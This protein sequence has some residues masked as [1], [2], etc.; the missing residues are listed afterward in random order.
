MSLGRTKTMYT[1]N[2]GIAPY[3]TDTLKGEIA[4]SRWIAVSYDES[5]N[6]VLQRG[7][8]DFILRYWN[9]STSRVSRRYWSRN[10]SGHNKVVDLKTC[11]NDSLDGIND[12]NIIQI[13]MDLNVNLSP[14]KDLVA[15]REE[16]ELPGFIDIGVCNLHIV[17]NAFK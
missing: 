3:V 9:Q 5:L 1:I 6:T 17:H 12:S 8:M 13:S 14:Y 7:Q 11:F 10:L 15:K 16:L 2:Y 4:E